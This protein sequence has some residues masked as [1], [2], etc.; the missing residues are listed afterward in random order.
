[1]FQ[2][3]FI[4]VTLYCFLLVSKQ[5]QYLFVICLLQYVQSLTLND[6]R[7]GR[8]KHVECYSNEINLRN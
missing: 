3:H 1:M 2:I 6:G 7:K 8:P 5:Y 4:G